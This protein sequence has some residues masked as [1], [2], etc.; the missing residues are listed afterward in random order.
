MDVAGATPENIPQMPSGGPPGEPPAGGPPP[1]P[2]NRP[3]HAPVHTLTRV[4]ALEAEMKNAIHDENYERAAELR[5]EI[6]RLRGE[7]TS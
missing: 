4:E 6:Q 5:D 7:Q 2:G 3:P 1:F